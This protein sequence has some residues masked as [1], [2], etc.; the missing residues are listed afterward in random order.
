MSDSNNS[1]SG[2][3]W[4]G[5]LIMLFAFGIVCIGAYP[6]HKEYGGIFEFLSQKSS[7][8]AGAIKRA[9][10]AEHRETEKESDGRAKCAAPGKDAKEVLLGCWH[11]RAPG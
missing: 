1:S 3:F 9:S 4:K 5:L 6:I 2:G 7:A 8:F 11:G 10:Q